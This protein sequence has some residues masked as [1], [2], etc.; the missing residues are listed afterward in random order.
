MKLQQRDCTRVQ[1]APLQIAFAL[2]TDDE[3]EVARLRM[4]GIPY[5]EISEDLGVSDEEAEKLWKQ[6]RQ[7]LGK[8]LFG[9]E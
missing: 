3:L 1:I 9:G 6:A 4:F 7:K 2:L 8:A 5:V